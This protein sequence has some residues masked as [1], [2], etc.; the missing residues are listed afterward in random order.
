[1]TMNFTEQLAEQEEFR[2]V[3]VLPWSQ[4]VLVE[5]HHEAY[6]LPRI[7]IRKRTRTAEQ[8]AEALQARWGVRSNMIDLLPKSHD[9]PPCAVI[10]VR[11]RNSRFAPE[12]LVPVSVDDLDERELTTQ[13]CVIVCSIVAGVPRDRGPFSKL[14]WIEEAQEW[15]RESVLDHRVDF[16]EDIRQFSAS[17]FFALVRF[18]TTH[19]PAYW[20]KAASVPNAHE[21]EVTRTI[22]RYCAQFLPPLIAARTDWNAWVTEE[23]GQPLHD[24]VSLRA[25]EQSA[26]GLAGLQITSTL[27]TE[28]LLACGCFDQRMPALRAH[29]PALMRYLEDAMA[30]QT[31]VKVPPLSIKQLQELGYLIEDAVAT[32]DALGVPDTLIHN[33]LNSGNILFDGVRAVFTD[34]SEACIGSPFLTFQHLRAQALEA[35]DTHT[36]APRL[37]EI[38]K[39]H[40]RAVLSESQIHRAF[41]LSPP[42]AIASYL[43][44]RDPSFSSPHRAGDSV[45]S[46]A[47][48]LARHMY[49]FAQFPEFVEALCR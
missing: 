11:T 13:E 2:V 40:W 49:R 44:G 43:C 15:I 26:H 18:G 31:S 36:W 42:L 32:M 24:V 10:E 5:R 4:M 28:E 46:Y 47:R 7:S 8:L 23:V 25:F 34:W 9:L 27:H 19:S 1:M 17:G 22:A 16:S 41:A 21:L 38:Y 29:L 30:S 39:G 12:G 33:D 48:S 20:L 6:Q 35:D 3:L 14:G 37:K 45:R